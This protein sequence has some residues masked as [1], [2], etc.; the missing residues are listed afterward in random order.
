MG[1]NITK[2]D[3]GRNIYNIATCGHNIAMIG[4]NIVGKLEVGC[5]ISFVTFGMP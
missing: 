1:R 5:V 3:H 2:V 4:R